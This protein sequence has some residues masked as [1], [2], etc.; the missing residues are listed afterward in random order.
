MH[1]ASR[2]VARA[3]C[4]SAAAAASAAE[5]LARRL[6]GARSSR[7]AAASARAASAAT[8]SRCWSIAG[9]DST[10]SAIGGARRRARRGR[11]REARDLVPVVL[12]R[13]AR[14]PW[15]L[16]RRARVAPKATST[17]ASSPS[18]GSAVTPGSAVE[19]LVLGVARGARADQRHAARRRDDAGVQARGDHG[20][21]PREER[22]G[23]ERVRPGRPTA[24]RGR[25]LEAAA[26][27][28]W[29][30][31]MGSSTTLMT[32]R[33]GRPATAP[34]A[35]RWPSS[36][37]GG[38]DD[39]VGAVHADAAASGGRGARATS[40]SSS[41]RM[42]KTVS[43]TTTGVAAGAQPCTN[44]AATAGRAPR[45]SPPRRGRRR[46]AARSCRGS[47]RSSRP[48]S[49]RRA[50]PR[51]RRGA[52]ARATGRRG[53]T[54]PRRWGRSPARAPR[55]R[56]SMWPPPTSE[57]VEL[58]EPRRE[59]VRPAGPCTARREGRASGS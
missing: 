43:G 56:A 22:R 55:R 9:S 17:A 26:S 45:G 11:S 37:D 16:A 53:A 8:R 18:A 40:S 51:P 31:P 58:R 28:R 32:W 6:V 13:R 54:S 59:R 39:D 49:R 35:A 21:G 1:L 27:S 52:S 57:Q 25:E 44:V 41:A 15:H 2:R 38:L 5:H 47:C 23:H 46:R 19:G 33:R 34:T 3:R 42:P 4:S 36:S 48:R 50:R 14:A 12:E 30:G 7:L 29:H 24:R 20:L 10:S